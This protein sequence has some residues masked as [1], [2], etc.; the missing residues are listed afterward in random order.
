MG[1]HHSGEDNHLT[2]KMR[3]M[4]LSPFFYIT[5]ARRICYNIFRNK[6]LSFIRFIVWKVLLKNKHNWFLFTND[7]HDKLHLNKFLWLPDNLSFQQ[8][9]LTYIT[10]EICTWTHFLHVQLD[11]FATRYGQKNELQAVPKLPLLYFTPVTSWGQAK[12]GKK[13]F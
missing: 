6:V 7:Q 12:E 5:F 3:G 11:F 4:Y 10:N 2:A 13:I 9:L 8:Y 1:H